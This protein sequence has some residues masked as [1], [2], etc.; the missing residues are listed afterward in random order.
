MLFR[1]PGN[2][3]GTRSDY[4]KFGL[5]RLGT[6]FLQAFG[7]VY[8]DLFEQLMSRLMWELVL[9]LVVEKLAKEE[10]KAEIVMVFFSFGEIGV[11]VVKEQR[12]QMERPMMEVVVRDTEWQRA[13][14]G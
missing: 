13:V 5:A 7:A 8:P 6:W 14:E 1:S 11:L 10:L 12:L 4:F 2:G 9:V 3:E